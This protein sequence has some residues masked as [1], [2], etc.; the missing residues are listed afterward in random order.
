V[1]GL[2]RSLAATAVVSLLVACGGDDSGSADA[3]SATTAL[4]GG[5]TTTFDT[6]VDAFA[7]SAANLPSDDRAAFAVGN[8]FFNDN[9]VVASASPEG[10]D[11]LGPLHN[12]VSC[13]GCHLHDGRAAPPDEGTESPGLLFRLSVSGE[14]EHGGPLPDPVYGGQLADIGIPGVEAEGEVQI[15]H[16]EISGRFGDGTPYTLAL[17]HYTVVGNFG[18]LASDVQISPRIAPAMVGM[19]L[20]EAIPED[21]IRAA[22]DP[23]DEDGDGISGRANSVWDDATSSFALG[24]FGWKANQPTVAQQV[25][26]A[27][28]GDLGI[29]SSSVPDQPCTLAEVACVAAP[30]GGEPELDDAKLVRVVFYSRTLG[31]PARRDVDDPEAMAGATTFASLGCSACH[32]TTFT[33]GDSDIAALEG[34]EIH[35]Y[36]DLLLHD[37]GPLLADGR[38]DG[39]ASG[40]EWRTAPLWGLGLVS[41]VNGHTRFLHDGRARSIEEAILWHG[42]EASDAQIAYLELDADD[43]ADL[44]SFLESL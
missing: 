22:E 6:T 36:T 21:V 25:A 7:R 15:T 16:T 18:D 37:M 44:L 2:A 26:H 3:P 12:A 4:S 40:S 41:T 35:P 5:A 27:F 19:G 23:D 28:Q 32:T 31:V 29:T 8:A 39:E 24:R 34:Q 11:G 20:L 10:R 42:G 13:S 38:P 14:D 1:T 17:P 43:R 30:S 33:T 9:W